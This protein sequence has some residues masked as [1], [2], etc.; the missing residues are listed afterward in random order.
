ME[1][2]QPLPPAPSLGST[3][4]NIIT[5]PSDVFTG[6]DKAESK[7]TLWII[8]LIVTILAVILTVAI[9]FTNEN[10]KSQRLDASRTVLEQRVADGKMTQDQLDKAI[11]GMERGSG[12]ILAIQSIAITIIFALFFFLS[13]LL[14]WLG[15][16]FILKSS[17]GYGKMLELSGI[18]MWIGTL[19]ILLQILMMIGLNSIYAQPSLS[20][21]FYNSFDPL[22]STHKFLAMI[23]FFSIWQ[24]IVI[25]IG[26]QKWC[27]KGIVFAMIIS[28]VVWFIT[29]GLMSLMGIG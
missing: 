16:K 5:S 23:N 1:E 14:L 6:L 18:P 12:L 8:P 24:T 17:A 10:L 9:G 25:G 11:E 15:S 3:I 21:F 4:L 26:L 28:F 13:A 22:N 27:N 29:L 2:Q 7:A 20:I 19:G